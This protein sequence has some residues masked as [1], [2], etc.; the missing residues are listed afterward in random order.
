M[1]FHILSRFPSFSDPQSSAT[2]PQSA[3]YELLR[4]SAD[5]LPMVHAIQADGA[6]SFRQIATVFNMRGIPAPR[7]GEWSAAQ[8]RRVLAIK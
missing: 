3:K 5:L 4:R 7:G 8:V 6:K 2:A 1:V